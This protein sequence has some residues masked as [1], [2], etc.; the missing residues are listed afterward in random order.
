MPWRKK[1]KA[2]TPPAKLLLWT[3]LAAALFGLIGLGQL[4]ED[5]LRAGRNHL[6]THAASGELVLVSIDDQAIRDIGRWPWP[7]S[8]HAQL[9]DRLTQAGA[10]RIIFDIVFESR[11]NPVDDRRLAEAISSSCADSCRCR[12]APPLPDSR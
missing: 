2:E 4:L 5:M 11:T 1:Q 3:G 6:H 7:R 9:T 12:A 10:S 8:F